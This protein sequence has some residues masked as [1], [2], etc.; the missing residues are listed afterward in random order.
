MLNQAWTALTKQEAF[1][2]QLNHISKEQIVIARFR[3]LQATSFQEERQRDSFAV[4]VLQDVTDSKRLEASLEARVAERTEQLEKEIKQKEHLM[5]EIEQALIHEQEMNAFRNRF[6]T[7]I[8]HE[9]RTPLTIIQTSIDLIERGGERITKQRQFEIHDRI[10][11]QIAHLVK[12]LDD[13]MMISKANTVGVEGV[14]EW[15]NV[16]PF[17]RRLEAELQQ[18]IRPTQTLSF[19][20]DALPEK[21]YMDEKLIRQMA[22]NLVSNA[23][24]YSPASNTIYFSLQGAEDKMTIT[25]QDHGIGI[26]H[27]AQS[28]LFDVFYRAQNVTN[29]SGTGIGLAIVK[30]VVDL[31]HGKIKVESQPEQGTTFI[32]DLPIKQNHT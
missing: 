25:V 4:L 2:T 11:D 16:F 28:H 9:F 18:L 5:R 32:I 1:T 7:M 19:S 20:Y 8:S 23:A 26:P 13:I 10:R 14:L 27:D 6:S 24:K 15:V 3:P 21:F 30:L 12:L 29:I 17:A 31:H 22:M